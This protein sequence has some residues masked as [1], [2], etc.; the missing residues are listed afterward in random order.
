MSRNWLQGL[1]DGLAQ[2][3]EGIQQGAGNNRSLSEDLFD[4]LTLDQE[5]GQNRAGG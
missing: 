4:G 2:L 1:R 3:S 5:T